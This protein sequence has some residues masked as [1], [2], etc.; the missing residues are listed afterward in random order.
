MSR[1]LLRRMRSEDRLAVWRR[2]R[3]GPILSVA[4]TRPPRRCHSASL[5]FDLSAAPGATGFNPPPTYLR[6]RPDRH[7][8]RAFVAR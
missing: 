4:V 2:A 3:G 8:G 6:A 5:A 7:R 1:R